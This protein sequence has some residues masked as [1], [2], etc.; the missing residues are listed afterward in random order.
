MVTFAS[1]TRPICLSVCLPFSLYV[2]V[3]GM[4]GHLVYK[5]ILREL[6]EILFFF[7]FFRRSEAFGNEV[8]LC[9]EKKGRRAEEEEK[10][11]RKKVR[12]SSPTSFLHFPSPLLFFFFSSSL[13]IR[14]WPFCGGASGMAY[15]EK[16]NITSVRT[17]SA[18]SRRDG[19]EGSVVF[20][21]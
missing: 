7:F 2:A 1:T 17:D 20:F 11:P 9:T 13:S 4:Y 16:E 19:G 5:E 14:R 8:G 21:V 6:Q 18:C 15:A 12:E 10:N 3:V